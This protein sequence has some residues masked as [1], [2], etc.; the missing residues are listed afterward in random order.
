MLY[1][2]SG[3][4]IPARWAGPKRRFRS[5]APGQRAGSPENDQ[6]KLITQPGNT[7]T[8]T[9]GTRQMTPA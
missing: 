7:A 6:R 2:R 5:R 3:I 9:V 8:T 4:G 1:P